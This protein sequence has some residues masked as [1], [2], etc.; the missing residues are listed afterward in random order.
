MLFGQLKL[1]SNFYHDHQETISG[2]LRGMVTGG[3]V[4]ALREH[5]ERD[6][7]WQDRVKRG[8]IGSGI[9]LATGGAMGALLDENKPFIEEKVNSTREK[10]KELLSQ[11][12]SK[13][14]VH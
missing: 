4:G 9:G 13:Y 7:K 5:K 1:G 10:L 12:R 14:T 2:A 3:I 11:E 6:T 8:L